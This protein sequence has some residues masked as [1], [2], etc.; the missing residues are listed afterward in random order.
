MYSTVPLDLL[1]WGTSLLGKHWTGSRIPESVEGIQ[2]NFCKNPLCTNYG[3][4]A[5]QESQTRRIGAVN[6]VRDTYTLKGDG[7]GVSLCCDLCNE[8]LPLKNNS[9]IFEEYTRL[10]AYL[11]PRQESCCPSNSCRNHLVGVSMPKAY[12]SFGMTSTGAK[13]FRCR[14]CGKT[15]SVNENPTAR[16]RVPDK[17]VEVFRFLVNK[18]PMK[19][20]S[21][22]AGITMDTLYRKIDFIHQRCLDFAS[23]QESR[24]PELPIRRLYLSV[25]RQEHMINWKQADDKRNIVLS[26]LGTADN[27]SG[28]I[29]GIHVNYDS[30]IDA[31]LVELDANEIGDNGIPPPFR[32]Y[33]RLWLAQDYQKALT[34]KS[35]KNG[36]KRLL[37]D[38]IQDVYDAVATRDD[39]E[40]PDCY[41]VETS[42]PGY[43]MQVH[44]EYT[45][46]AHFLFLSGLLK[47]VE[48]I[49]FFLDQESGI[50]AAC[51]SSFAKEVLEKRCDAF[52]VR[53][54]KDLTINEKRRL[55]ADAQK[56]MDKLRDSNPFLAEISDYELRIIIIK[57]RMRE[58]VGIGKWRDRWLFCPFPDMSEPEKAICW[59]TDLHDQ[60][61]DEDHLARLYSKATLH[62]I[63][64][65]FMQARRRLSLLERPIASASSE[66]R[67]WHGY[68]PYNPAIVG[69]VLDIFRVFYNYIEI[70]ADKQ[71]PAVRLGLSKKPNTFSEILNIFNTHP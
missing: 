36:S 12:Q 54:R 37:F 22:L 2:V 46:Y 8:T 25:D 69:K 48:K 55:K 20:M 57:D 5:S 53:V 4:P 56:E 28:Y 14:R 6:Y 21:E 16:Q 39:V 64:R 71:T 52:Y 61:Y 67:K 30:G 50:R 3:R 15:F 1:F 27:K 26:A 9:S 31:E 19:R 49:R 44:S 32:K 66:G 47:N 41:S 51:L 58:L 42:L 68:S 38:G 70:G 13:R 43:G 33:A 59:L 40:N 24:L 10:S 60:A 17:N 7:K 35:R 34:H 23:A 65:F 18:V 45:L 62:G 29:F 63:D 11:I